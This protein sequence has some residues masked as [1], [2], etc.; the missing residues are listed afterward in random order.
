MTDDDERFTF[1]SVEYRV[2]MVGY[3]TRCPSTLPYKTA[4]GGPST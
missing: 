2:Y 1:L 3:A 4:T